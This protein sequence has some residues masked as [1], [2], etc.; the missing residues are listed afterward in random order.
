MSIDNLAVSADY[1][2]TVI[3]GSSSVGRQFANFIMSPEGQAIL[4]KHGFTP[5]R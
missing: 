5:G 3:A 1:G 2:L 4:T